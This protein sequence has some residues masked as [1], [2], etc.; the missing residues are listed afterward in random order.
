MLADWTKDRYLL[1]WLLSADTLFARCRLSSCCVMNPSTRSLAPKHSYKAA[2]QSG[3]GPKA[4]KHE[5]AIRQA[6]QFNIANY[7]GG[8]W[9]AGLAL[10]CYSASLCYSAQVPIWHL[11]V[12]GSRRTAVCVWLNV[13]LI[14]SWGNSTCRLQWPHSLAVCTLQSVSQSVSPSATLTLSVSVCDGY[15][16]KSENKNRIMHNLGGRGAIIWF[17]FWCFTCPFSTLHEVESFPLH[18][19]FFRVWGCFLCLLFLLQFSAILVCPDNSLH[20]RGVCPGASTSVIPANTPHKMPRGKEAKFG[21][22]SGATAKS[23]VADEYVSKDFLG[24]QMLHVYYSIVERCCLLQ[25]LFILPSA[26]VPFSHYPL[27]VHT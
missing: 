21:K 16:L 8:I 25:Y 22:R 9:F 11:L 15:I 10:C 18:L 4:P 6:Q 27:A 1:D 17:L 12:P 3:Q 26:H 24:V 5:V 23:V 2:R 13:Y 20:K 14:K 7:F 19:L